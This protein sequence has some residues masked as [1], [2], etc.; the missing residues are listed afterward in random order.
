[1]DQVTSS[2]AVSRGSIFKT[3][4]ITGNIETARVMMPGVPPGVMMPGVSRSLAYPSHAASVP[5]TAASVGSP[6][7]PPQP[8]PVAPVPAPAAPPSAGSAVGVHGLKRLIPS[9]VVMDGYSEII[10]ADK[11][12]TLRELQRVEY[13]TDSL[14]FRVLEGFGAKSGCED[15]LLKVLVHCILNIKPGVPAPTTTVNANAEILRRF[16]WEMLGVQHI[17]SKKF[18]AHWDS[19]MAIE[20]MGSNVKRMFHGTDERAMEMIKH[21]GLRA[22]DSHMNGYGVYTAVDPALAMLYSPPN[23]DGVQ[24]LLCVE[25]AI[26][27]SIVVG[28][29][30]MRHFGYDN[31]QRR[32]MTATDKDYTMLVSSNS[33]QVLPK[34]A[35]K[36]R[37]KACYCA[38][39]VPTA[40]IFNGTGQFHV[41]VWH[42]AWTLH[43][44]SMLALFP[45]GRAAASAAKASTVAR[46]V[47]RAVQQVLPAANAAPQQGSS[48]KALSSFHTLIGPGRHAPQQQQQP[49]HP[50]HLFNLQQPHPAPQQQPPVANAAQQLPLQIDRPVTTV[51]HE[52]HH[53]VSRGWFVRLVGLYKNFRAF[54]GLVSEV[55]RIVQY[56]GGVAVQFEVRLLGDAGFVAQLLGQNRLPKSDGRK[57]L[58]E[59]PE[60]II[61]KL[62][63]MSSRRSTVVRETVLPPP[64]TTISA[65]MWAQFYPAAAKRKRERE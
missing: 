8:S 50:W 27:H 9:A 56:R 10:G 15:L 53:G 38:H 55:M 11:S 26:G 51:L 1:M 44:R 52:K 36:I 13:T 14:G 22:G 64:Y 54:E 39:S 33:H 31:A 21:L 59:N 57:N 65:D 63:Q 62:G 30:T 49:S 19:V 61:V 18:K 60:H 40:S 35:F 20:E 46:P 6:G 28:D 41:A 7:V 29:H 42:A 2:S 16:G 25:V 17:K 32:I 23:G 3:A 43:P 34:F 45:E 5:T 48:S 4:C 37:Q 24:H 58:A 47:A 12:T